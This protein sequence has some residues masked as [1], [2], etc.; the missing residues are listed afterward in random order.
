MFFCIDS[1][2]GD[3]YIY[4]ESH[5]KGLCGCRACTSRCIDICHARQNEYKSDAKLYVK[6]DLSIVN[7]GDNLEN[8]TTSPDVIFR[9]NTFDRCK[10]GDWGDA[11]I[12]FYPRRE[13]EEGNEPEMTIHHVRCE[14]I[15]EDK[16]R[17]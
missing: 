9:S 4:Y 8:L 3:C 16:K 17:K 5:G 14:D 13:E 6:D 2:P 1:T 11:V 12:R 7:V 10:Y 15:Q